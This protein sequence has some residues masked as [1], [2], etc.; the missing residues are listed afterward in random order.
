M[1]ALIP[2]RTSDVTGDKNA[3]DSSVGNTIS[4]YEEICILSPLYPEV[5]PVCLAL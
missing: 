2:T 3:L 4:L 1:I 5:M